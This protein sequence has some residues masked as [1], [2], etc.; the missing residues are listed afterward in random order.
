MIKNMVNGV[1]DRYLGRFVADIDTEQLKMDLWRG[2]VELTGLQL[3]PDIFQRHG[4]PLSISGGIEKVS[5][6]ISRTGPVKIDIERV[7]AV[8]TPLVDEAARTV[9]TRGVKASEIEELIR[10]QLLE[11]LRSTDRDKS[12]SKSPERGDSLSPGRPA[13]KSMSLWFLERLADNVQIKISDVRI[14]YDHGPAQATC[15]RVT[16]A[17][18]SLIA[19]S[20]SETPAAQTAGAVPAKKIEVEGFRVTASSSSAGDDDDPAQPVLLDIP[21]TRMTVNFGTAK[22]SYVTGVHM[23][24]MRVNAH[25]WQL[26]ALHELQCQWA[27]ATERDQEA[28]Q[29]LSETAVPAEA[30]KRRCVEHRNL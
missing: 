20:E 9:R 17:L 3:K 1:I 27:R 18:R 8:V 22:A 16:V 19:T 11:A 14:T 25:Q 10:G 28:A 29:K 26:R 12:P 7:H 15:I 13:D 30:D 5:L 21:N 6:N 24:E 4:L 2:Q 23:L